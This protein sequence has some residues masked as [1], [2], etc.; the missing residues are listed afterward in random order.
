MGDVRAGFG[1]DV[2]GYEHIDRSANSERLS[3]KPLTDIASLLLAIGLQYKVQT[4]ALDCFQ[5]K[6]Q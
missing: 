5:Q 2:Y 3:F 4:N 1:V 6:S